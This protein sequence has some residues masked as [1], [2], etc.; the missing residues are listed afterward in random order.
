MGL[1]DFK[2]LRSRIAEASAQTFRAL[3]NAHPAESFYAFALYTTD[4]AVGVNPSANSDGAYRNT[5]DRETAEEATTKFLESNGISLS[6]SLLG[7]HRWSPY[8]WQYDCAES[9]GFN[10]VNVLINN[11]GTGFYDEHDAL[12]FEKFKAGILASMV[13]GLQDASAAGAFGIGAARDPVT[14]FCSVASS[15]EAIWFEEDSAKRLNVP[16]S[17]RIFF[18]ERIKYIADG[19][20]I[21]PADSQSVHG[22]YLAHMDAAARAE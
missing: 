20:E 9:E 3:R 19:E 12:G 4:D 16:S 14:L 10:I 1:V 7:D 17:F 5:V 18:E 13:L 22:L 2:L 21:G 15:E 6:A 11:E 8:D